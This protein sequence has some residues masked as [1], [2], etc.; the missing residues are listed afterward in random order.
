MVD[1]IERRIEELKERLRKTPVN[2]GTEKERAR[3][4]AQ[5]ARLEERKESVK[6]K[7]YGYGYGVKKRGDLTIC[8]VGYPSTGKSTLLNKLTNARSETGDYEF[9]TIEVIPGI[10]K[11]NGAEIQI[12]DVPGLIEGASKGKG[13]GKEVI[14]VI[15]NCD[16][17]ILLT[18][19]KR[20]EKVDK[21]LEEIYEAGIR[22]NRDKPDIKIQ[23][24]DRG[25]LSIISTVN[26]D[27]DLESLK[28][29]CRE[30]NLLN[31][32]IVVRSKINLDEFIDAL[33]GN[34]VYIP[35]IL[36]VNKLDEMG[37]KE[38]EIVRKKFPN[39]ILI[40]AKKGINIDRLKMEIWRKSKL[41]RIF[42]KKIGEEPDYKEPLI[43][44]EGATVKD[45]CEKIHREFVK[46]FR[47]ARI[48]GKS[49]RFEGQKVGLEHILKDED[50]VELHI[51]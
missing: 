35:F 26:I 6:K 7:G 47:Y 46:N 44:K 1:L 24:K 50:V 3:L 34:R 17:L 40:S 8:L 18:D 42:M 13:R 4:K 48:W 14:S 11:L 45:V 19:F 15:R 23:K 38:I 32:D 29:I 39:A 36:A 20:L 21:L 49:A 16:M 25:G 27:I 30:F 28:E 41:M 12:L 43:M 10:M 37:E 5:I 22:L 9:T 33:S 2:K 51:R 31:A